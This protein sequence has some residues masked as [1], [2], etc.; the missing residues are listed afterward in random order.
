[1]RWAAPTVSPAPC[2]NCAHRLSESRLDLLG[3]EYSCAQPASVS[4]QM[5]RLTR[6]DLLSDLCSSMKNHVLVLRERSPT[7]RRS[8]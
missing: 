8:H 5:R 7:V 1:M 3:L 2:W 4:H 6:A